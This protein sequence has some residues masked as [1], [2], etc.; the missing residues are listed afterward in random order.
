V[1]E[2]PRAAESLLDR[3]TGD[4][5][6]G[7]LVLGRDGGSWWLPG[8][9]RYLLEVDEDLEEDRRSG[10]GGTSPQPTSRGATW[11][12]RSAARATSWSRVPT[13]TT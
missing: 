1:R 2:G 5:D 6:S 3:L 12:S 10:I 8:E 9:A 11:S 7:T 13:P 4:V